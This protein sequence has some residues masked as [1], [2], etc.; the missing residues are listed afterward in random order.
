MNVTAG[1]LSADELQPQ[2]RFTLCHRG[3]LW[4][5]LRHKDDCSPQA[6]PWQ[7]ASVDVSMPCRPGWPG[8]LLG[9][10][11]GGEGRPAKL[12][13]GEGPHPAHPLT[14]SMFMNDRVGNLA[15]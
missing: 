4:L 6:L 15:A 5:S 3:A 14:F 9:V 2:L 7:A 12:A 11:C 10:R 1:C 13:L 8:L